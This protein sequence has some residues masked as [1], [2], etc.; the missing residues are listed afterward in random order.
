[1]LGA[2]KQ[3]ARTNEL[4]DGLHQAGT[5]LGV[6]GFYQG[7]DRL[8]RHVAVSVID[9]HEI[10]APTPAGHEIPDVARLAVMIDRPAPVPDGDISG[11]LLLQ[12]SDAGFFEQRNVRIGCITKNETLI[13][14]R[15]ASHLSG[16]CQHGRKDLINRLIVNRESDDGARCRNTDW[17]GR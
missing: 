7:Q 13:S 9:N 12:L 10:V 15:C 11:C 2:G 6:N 4:R 8:S 5:G 16:G 14:A 3:G 17:H 1:M